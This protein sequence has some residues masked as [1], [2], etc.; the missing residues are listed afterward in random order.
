MC[1]RRLCPPVVSGG[2]TQPLNL[3]GPQ[4]HAQ[5]CHSQSKPPP[6]TPHPGPTRTPS[7][8]PKL[9]EAV[10][11]RATSIHSQHLPPWPPS[12]LL[13]DPPSSQ[14]FPAGPRGSDAMDLPAPRRADMP[15]DLGLDAG[16]GHTQLSGSG[17]SRFAHAANPTQLPTGLST[18]RVHQRFEGLR[19]RSAPRSSSPRAS[20]EHGL[21]LGLYTEL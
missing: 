2:F 16:R 4:Q 6:R 3:I 17:F 20:A 9:L 8:A 5:H 12:Q 14:P 1:G 10:G 18:T 11:S 13:T 7:T 15:R 19:R 21:Q